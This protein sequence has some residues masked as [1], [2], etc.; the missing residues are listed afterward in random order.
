MSEHSMDFE[1]VD[2]ADL[3]LLVRATT[4]G[5][6]RVSS[7]LAAPDAIKVLRDLADHWEKSLQEGRAPG[8]PLP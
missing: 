8:R 4:D 1:I 2:G 6:V 7:Q 5:D 3:A